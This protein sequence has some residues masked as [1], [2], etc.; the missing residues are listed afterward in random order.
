MM[1]AWEKLS[2][3]Q[4]ELVQRLKSSFGDDTKTK[5]TKKK[6]FSPSKIVYSHGGCP[7][8]W[9][10]MFGG[11]E[12]TETFSHVSS[13]NM[14]SGVASHDS[15]QRM[16]KDRSGLPIELEKE[17]RFDDPPIHAYADGVITMRDGSLVPLEIKTTRTEAYQ[18][19]ERNFSGAEANILQLLVYMKILD[20]DMGLLL[21]EDRNDFNN[22]I[23][24]IYMTEENRQLVDDAFEW[25]KETKRAFDEDTL[26]MYFKGR[27]VNSKIC[28]ECPVRELCDEKGQGVIE[29]PLLRTK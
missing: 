7:R 26:P 6:S 12:T 18:V 20:S 23:I 2:E 5:F 29:L 10:F 15:L 25:M 14:A 8:F 21:Y 17:L 13:R 9:T 3:D 4:K 24:P 22:L 16:I 27:R 11:A 19:R 1:L 28:Q